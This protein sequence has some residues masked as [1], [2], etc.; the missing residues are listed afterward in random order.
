L[1]NQTCCTPSCTPGKCGGD[2]CGGTCA[3]AS[4]DVCLVNQTCCTPTCAPGTCG[5]DGCGGTCACPSGETCGSAG[6][7]CVADWAPN[8][9]QTASAGS[10]WAEFRVFG[11]SV[12]TS[13]SLEVPGMPL[14]PLTLGF[15]DT[16]SG[17]LDGVPSGTMVILHATDST[18]ATAQT[19]S[20]PYLVDQAP[21]TD[22]CGGTASTTPTC[23]PLSR[24]MVSF[25]MDDSYDTQDLLARPLLTQYGMK[26]TIFHITDNLAL[27]GLLPNAQ[28]LAAAGNE[29]GSHTRTHAD[30]TTLTPAELDDELGSSKQYLLDNVGSP[31]ESF[32]S[33]G[34]NYND[35][36]LA[37]IKRY[38]RS[39]RTVNPGLNYMGN[40]VYELNA[41]GVYNDSTVASVCA[42]LADAATYK[43]WRILV[44]HD[45]TTDPTSTQDLLY[46][47]ADFERILQCAQSTPGLDVVT[48]KEGADKLRCASP[49]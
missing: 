17:G 33:P 28:S 13:V 40:A 39:H 38:Y 41:D 23:K 21:L 8:W 15:G 6:R 25:T 44:F 10:F 30:L 32:A 43:G 16:W 37:A 36:V 45:F 42:S 11:G 34:G 27:Y 7:C 19:V 47:I 20:F 18:G 46:P 2:G 9:R 31:V 3:C 4:G 5:S 35:T 1:A 29:V 48:V 26:A 49:P 24:G 14:Y 22:A 12:A